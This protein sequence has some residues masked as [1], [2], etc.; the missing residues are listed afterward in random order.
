[1]AKKIFVTG[2]TGFLGAYIISEL[3][4]QG[5]NVRALRRKQ[6]LPFF[7]PKET[8]EKVEWVTGD[9]LDTFS[10]IEAIDGVDIV[11]HAAAKVSFQERERKDLL[12][13]NIDGTSNVVNV[14][15]EKNISRLVYISSVA[16]I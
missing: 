3:V 10:L 5:Y 14:M 6:Q 12:R 11:V 4:Q 1:M 13:T 8:A 7:I 2:G 15:L 16:A 9:I